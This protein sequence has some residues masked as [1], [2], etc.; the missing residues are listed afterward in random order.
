MRRV[1]STAG[2]HPRTRFKLWQE[3]V[4]DRIGPVEQRRRADGPF[5]GEIEIG[6]VGPLTFSRITQGAIT[7]TITADT[8]RR[9][10]DG[11]IRVNFRLAGSSTFQQHGRE[12]LQGA[13]DF[14]VVDHHP[15]VLDARTDGQTLVM[16]LPRERLE[17]VLGPARLFAA[18]TMTAESATTRLVTTFFGD[19]LRVNRR[20]SP[21]AAERM[22]A[23]GVDLIVAALAER[24]AR[25]VPRTLHGSVVV[26][27]AKAHVEANLG[28]PSLDPPRL[29]AAMGVSLR[30]LQELF[31]ERGQHISDWIWERR[32]AAA[33]KG[34]SD[35]VSL[36]RPIGVVAYECG[37]ASQ[38][39]FARRFKDRH[40][41][42]P[43]A[44][45]EAAALRL[46]GSRPDP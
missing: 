23:I 22:A 31:H 41:L 43:R 12:A 34:L 2:I 25:E 27:R 24:M 26:Q 15:G 38:A 21:E 39:H 37:F 32:L 6:A 20:L 1:F 46:S 45:R 3:V 17:G 16:A 19:L 4:A 30:R 8:V 29:A 18:L 35:P 10:P 36:H 9:R 11:L 14:T 42:S 5:A 44:Y 40:G 28:D 13:G 7:T 33:A